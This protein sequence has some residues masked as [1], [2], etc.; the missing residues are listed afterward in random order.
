MTDPGWPPIMWLS[1]GVTKTPTGGGD[2]LK[3]LPEGCELIMR[4]DGRARVSAWKKL[5]PL[6][7][8]LNDFER[9]PPAWYLPQ[10]PLWWRAAFWWFRNPFH[11]VGR[12]VLGVCD[13]NYWVV[14]TRRDGYEH[15]VRDDGGHEDYLVGWE[16][17]YIDLP[18]GARL[19]WLAWGSLRPIPT[20]FYAGWQPTGFAGL[21]FNGLAILASPLLLPLLLWMFWWRIISVVRGAGWRP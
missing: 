14:I 12:Y 15:V 16:R 3:P 5:N 4:I 9:M 1:C 2:E 10:R 18:S 6:W 17:G 8:P 13:Q 19:P 7:W 11:N 20:K 21:K